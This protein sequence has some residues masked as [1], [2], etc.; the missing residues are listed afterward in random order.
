MEE[1][2]EMGKNWKVVVNSEDILLGDDFPVA[3]V[4]AAFAN[5]L[6]INTESI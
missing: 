1:S 4:A 3:F 5:A 2:V 6:Y